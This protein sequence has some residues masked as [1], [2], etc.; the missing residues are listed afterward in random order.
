MPSLLDPI[1]LGDLDLPN[2][3]AM[4]PM[5]RSRAGAGDVPTALNALYYAQ[6]AEAGL[7]ISEATNVSPRSCAF[8]R[9]PGIYG[10]AQVEGWRRVADAVHAAGGR[11]F[12]QLWHCGRI[13][14]EGILGGQPPLSPSG[15]NDDLGA[16]QVW[17]QLAN[18]SYIR[19]AATRSQA[20]TLEEVEAA[21]GEYGA[22][23]ANAWAAGCDGVEVHAANGYLPHQFLSPTTNRREDAYGGTLPKRA[24][25]LREVVEAVCAAVPRSRVGVRISPLADYNN[26]RDPDPDE[27]YGYVTAMLH[28]FGIAYVHLADTNAWAGRPDMPRLLEVV[29]PRFPGTLIANGGLLPSQASALLEEGSVG[30]VAFGR[31]FIANPDL[32]SRVRVGAPLAEP[33]PAGWYGGSERGYTYDPRLGA[34]A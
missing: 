34:A 19:I 9:A 17:G 11:L 26:P 5:T 6:R 27:T 32:V 2:R 24:R 20:M 28:E 15:V 23:A 22:G 7:I 12:V 29:R 1:R 33:S 14:A 18:G 8:E 21:I 4:A 30:M 3:I 13:G 25:F 31:P 16:L 10:A